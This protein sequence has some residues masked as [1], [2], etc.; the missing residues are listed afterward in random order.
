MIKSQQK[1]KISHATY[2]SS[3][4]FYIQTG[5]YFLSRLNLGNKKTFLH[6]VP[7]YFTELH[8]LHLL[9]HEQRNVLNANNTVLCYI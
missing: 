8:E 1:I 6:T 4:L 7:N 3:Y 5:H 2:F 9:I